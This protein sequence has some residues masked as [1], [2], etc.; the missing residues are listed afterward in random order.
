MS[1]RPYQ[2]DA[3][4][5]AREAIRALLTAKRRPSVCVV[6]PTGGGKTRLGAE[7]IAACVA[8]GGRAWWAVNRYEVADQ[9]FD[10]LTARG[11]RCGMVCASSAKA[12]QPYASIQ[13]GTFQSLIARD[14]TLPANLII[15]DECHHAGAKTFAEYVNRYPSVPLIGLTATPERGDGKGLGGMFEEI[16]VG[17]RVKQLIELG[18]LVSANLIRPGRKLRSGEIAQRPVDAWMQHAWRAGQPMPRTVVFSPSVLIAEEHAEQF[19]MQGIP[20]VMVEGNTD[21]GKRR[22][23]FA[24]LRSGKVPVLC[25]VYIATEGFDIPAIECVTLARGCGAA[26]TYLQMVGRGL[27]PF[28]D[29]TACTVLDLQGIS[30]DHGHPEDDRTYSLTGRGISEPGAAEPTVTQAY[31]KVCSAALGPDDLTCPICGMERAAPPQV[32]TGD[33]LEK[34]QWKRAEGPT[35]R[36]ATLAR[37]FLA[38]VGKARADGQPWKEAAVMHKFRAVYGEEP[39]AEVMQAAEVREA[40]ERVREAARAMMAGKT[41]VASG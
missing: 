30:W 9:A 27:R 36:A 34:Y 38:I 11:L 23:A 16:V 7:M 4:T 35:A 12:P 31:C 22:Q 29:K 26:G 13:V 1:L 37:W 40:R 5:A 41:E 39:P 10:A 32:I 6:L 20:A 8:K 17:A 3:Y 2:Q 25:N 18:H 19:R 15:F 24:D 33:R 14:L 21:P 28:E